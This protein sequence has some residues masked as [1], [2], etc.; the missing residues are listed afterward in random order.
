MP[1]I[2]VKRED[3]FRR[4][5]RTYTEEE[6]DELC[7]EFGIELDE[8]VEEA[9]GAAE[10]AAADAGAASGGGATHVVYKI[11]IPANRYDLLCPEGL[12]RALNVFRGESQAPVRE[13]LNVRAVREYLA[14]CGG[15]ACSGG[16]QAGVGGRG[17]V[18]GTRG[19]A[20]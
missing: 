9:T 6:F 2:S 1:T 11:D 16:V 14:P 19:G 13:G 4:L 18:F 8:V 7:F 3:L 15:V 12:A 5:G 10:G 20:G 17:V